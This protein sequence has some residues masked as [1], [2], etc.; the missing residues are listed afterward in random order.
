[1]SPPSIGNLIRWHS[2][3]FGIS[4]MF[5]AVV[6]F[7]ASIIVLGR[8]VEQLRESFQ[9]ST[10]TQEVLRQID[11][12]HMKMIGTEMIV[13]GYGLTGDASFQRYAKENRMRMV[14]AMTT[15]GE[16][17][18]QEPALDKDYHI[19]EGWVAQH[20]QLYIDLMDGGPDQRARIVDATVN[21]QK[22]EARAEAM[23]A[24]DRMD[25]LE[26]K[27]LAERRARAEAQAAKSFVMAIAIAVFAFVTGTIGFGLTFMPHKSGL[28]PR[29]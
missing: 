16:L 23:R 22:R 19:L 20:Q 10:R 4:A 25:G 15:L 5:A 26:Q 17:V 14:A 9:L 1:M 3:E 11:Q 24:L 28:A 6:L 8:N 7:V 21:P 13:R 18:R 2:R 29:W 27:L 12:V